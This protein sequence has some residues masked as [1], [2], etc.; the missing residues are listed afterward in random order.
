[1]FLSGGGLCFRLR[2][3]TMVVCAGCRNRLEG[4]R[5]SLSLDVSQ[6]SALGTGGGVEPGPGAG[7]P[8][9]G[10]EAAAGAGTESGLDLGAWLI[11]GLPE[12]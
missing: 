3:G 4:V 2:M 5:P 9:T 10:E 11:T 7:V 1:M 8:G 12:S 6:S